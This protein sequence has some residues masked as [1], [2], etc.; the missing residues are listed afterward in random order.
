MYILYILYRTY[1]DF[2]HRESQSL[3]KMHYLIINKDTLIS[4]NNNN[5][6]N[7][8]KVTFKPS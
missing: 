1:I 3:S 4:N 7:I 2:V 5:N 8:Y 6:N